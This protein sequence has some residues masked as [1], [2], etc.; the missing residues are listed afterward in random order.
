MCVRAFCKNILFGSVALCS[1]PYFAELGEL[2][3]LDA[4]VDS[5]KS[6]NKIV[7]LMISFG[8]RAVALCCTYVFSGQNV[9]IEEN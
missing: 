3:A 4:G 5:S 8:K 7:A 1:F 2:G 6:I 9:A